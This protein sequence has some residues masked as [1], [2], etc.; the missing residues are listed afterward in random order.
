MELSK[1]VPFEAGPHDM[2]ATLHRLR[3][4]ALQLAFPGPVIVG[5]L[6]ILTAGRFAEPLR[7]GLPGTLLLLL[8]LAAWELQRWHRL[9]GAWL[10]VGGCLV[11]G[12]LVVAW[13]QVGAAACLL[14][15]PVGLATLYV[16]VA[17]GAFTALAS[18]LYLLLAPPALLPADQTL[19]TVALL[20]V[21]SV[22]GLIW[23]TLCPLLTALEWS[24]SSH[25]Q[26]RR[27]LEEVRDYQVQLKQTL[28]DLADA[29]LQLT[30]LNR[31]ADGL[32][33][34]AEDA[35]RAKEQFVA[36]VSH[37]LRTP[38]NMILG[39]CEMIMRA[40][41][42]YGKIPPALLADLAVVL[43]NSQHLSS[44]IDDVLDLSQIEAGRMALTKERVALREIIEAAAVAVRPLYGSKGLYLETEVEDINLYCD[45][46]RIRE[47]VLNLLSNAGRFTEQGGVRICAWREG[48]DAVVTVADTGAGIPSEALDRVFRPFE[49]LDGSVG[50]RHGGT[51]LGLSISRSFVELHDGKM[52]LESQVGAG[53]TFY[54]RLPIDP[55]APIEDA[56]SR[57]FS[58]YWHYEER[59][60]RSLAPP[61]SP[62]ARY[63]ILEAGEAL[64]RL[65]SRYL[66]G[67]EIVAVTSLEEATEELNR[68]PTRAL[69]ANGPSVTAT[70][71]HLNSA[72][73]PYGTPA[74][75]Y[76][77]PGIEEASGALGVSGYLVKPVSREALLT[78]LERLQLRGRR[79]LV[80]DDEPEA[81]RL[82]WRMLDSAEC[83]YR[84]L[85]A[86]DGR[87]AL[88]ILRTQR[89]DAVLLDLVMPEL[90]GFQLLAAKSADPA[91]RDIPVI[92]ISARD[93]AGQPVVTNGLAVTR[94]GGL[95]ASQILACTEALT[96]LLSTSPLPGDPEPPRKPLA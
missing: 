26:S 79:L 18:S 80:V 56:V 38:L 5:L 47:V 67:A 30:R 27:R 1:A 75:A 22:L 21:W 51:G 12:L 19:R 35:R 90:D 53:T 23:L 52:W 87:Q 94:G 66:D 59:T 68:V 78:A 61:A 54:V 77:I 95:S 28:S 43:R 69:L 55:P 31:L 46:T 71:E 72:A 36:N 57:W 45:R 84:V 65:M 64:Q 11:G 73:L 15:V 74:I 48:N 2:G 82:F 85:T 86:A 83:G 88:E 91:L 93:P 89:P 58:P 14:A 33:Q 41:H 60:R 24:W 10:L 9:A 37:E 70:L 20:E 96:H 13:A 49:Q 40:P 44:L 6:L 76:S 4:E 8:P 42:T 39:F 25:E 92:V 7:A 81:V 50:R 17:G 32:R 16:S 34:A 62:R 29:N 3:G 63:V